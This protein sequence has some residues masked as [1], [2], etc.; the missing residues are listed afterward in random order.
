MAVLRGHDWRCTA[1]ADSW[2]SANGEAGLQP[3]VP[4]TAF[5]GGRRPSSSAASSGMQPLPEGRVQ[6]AAPLH[7]ST[8]LLSPSPPSPR[9]LQKAP[10]RTR[11]WPGASHPARGVRCWR[12]RITNA[13]IQATLWLTPRGSWPLLWQRRQRGGLPGSAPRPWGRQGGVAVDACLGGTH[14]RGLTTARLRC[15]CRVQS[16]HLLPCHVL[17]GRGP[18]RGGSACLPQPSTA[19]VPGRP[20]GSAMHEGRRSEQHGTGPMTHSL[21]CLGLFHCLHLL[22]HRQFGVGGG[23]LQR[24]SRRRQFSSRTCGEGPRLS[25]GLSRDRQPRHPTHLKLAAQLV[26][27]F[28]RLHEP[29]LC[30][31]LRGLRAGAT[32]RGGGRN[33]GDRGLDGRNAAQPLPDWE[34]QGLPM[35]ATLRSGRAGLALLGSPALGTPPTTSPHGKDCMN[36]LPAPPL[37]AR[38]PLPSHFS[39]P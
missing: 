18:E 6:R 20:S 24:I 17:L 33:V 28:E 19:A 27:G 21:K 25:P 23:S 10:S 37:H 34:V 4:R 31:V 8:P 36:I 39:S 14:G 26:L 30:L 38:W 3:L 12:A 29:R 11:A 9:Q 1:A 5:A 13:G 16:L 22:M 15:Q 32:D 2:P 7:S 35:S